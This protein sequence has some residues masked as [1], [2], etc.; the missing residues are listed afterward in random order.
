MTNAFHTG[1][2]VLAS[3]LPANVH[4][5]LTVRTEEAVLANALIAIHEIS[6]SACVQAGRRCTVVDEFLT[7]FSWPKEIAWLVFLNNSGSFHPPDN[8]FLLNALR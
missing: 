3:V 8:S 2:V 6:A 5:L 1:A 7:V 4:V